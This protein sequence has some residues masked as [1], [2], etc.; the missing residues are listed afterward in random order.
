M[1]KSFLTACF[2]IPNYIVAFVHIAS[3]VKKLGKSVL[4]LLEVEVCPHKSGG[5]PP[6]SPSIVT[7]MGAGKKNF[8][9]FI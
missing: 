2:K 7:Y 3:D 5:A 1:T 9:E 8:R 6:P 4:W